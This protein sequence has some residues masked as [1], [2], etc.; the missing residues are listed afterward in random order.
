MQS[1]QL[2]VRIAR[3]CDMVV[4]REREHVALVW[5]SWHLCT[6]VCQRDVTQ[7]FPALE[8]QADDIEEAI[9]E[10][11]EEHVQHKFPDNNCERQCYP[12]AFPLMSN[13]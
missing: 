11:F 5:L 3:R 2:P 1:E 13:V 12:I 10:F 9:L 7:H 4:M 6:G 8:G